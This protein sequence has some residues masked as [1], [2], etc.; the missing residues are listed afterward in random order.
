ED[1]R[2]THLAGLPSDDRHG[3]T[4]EVD[5]DLLAGPVLLPQDDIDAAAP[6]AV[7][8]AE[9]A[10]LQPVGL[11]LLV[12]EPEQ[13]ECDA[14]SLQLPVDLGPVRNRPLSGQRRRLGEEP[15]IER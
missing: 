12:L 5:K 15:R 1:L 9:A 13:L 6:L 14:F 8:L 2:I 3:L 4:G 10:V 7:A 11:S